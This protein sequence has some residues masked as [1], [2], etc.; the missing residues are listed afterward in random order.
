MPTAPLRT[1]GVV[2]KDLDKAKHTTI[3]EE[4]GMMF[5]GKKESSSAASQLRNLT[6]ER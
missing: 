2:P 5:R 1:V 6:N 4:S 3:L